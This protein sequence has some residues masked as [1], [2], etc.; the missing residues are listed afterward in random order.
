MIHSALIENTASKLKL[1]NTKKKTE[2]PPDGQTNTH[3]VR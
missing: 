3:T 1:E 2:R